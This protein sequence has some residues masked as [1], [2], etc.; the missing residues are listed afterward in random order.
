MKQMGFFIIVLII[1]S[2]IFGVWW[3]HRNAAL[4]RQGVSFVVPYPPAAVAEAIERIHNQGAKAAIRSFV[5]GVN[6]TPLGPS[7]FATGTKWGDSGEIAISRDPA[8]SLVT[9]RALSLYVGSHPRTHNMRG[10]AITHGLYSMLGI[11][12]FAAKYN[13]WHGGLESRITRTIA[14]ASA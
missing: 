12:P 13:R 4:A 7:A 8:G 9:A 10:S 5:A 6:V 11:T 3:N 14:R 1:A 2:I